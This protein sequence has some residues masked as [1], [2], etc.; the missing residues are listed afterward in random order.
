MHGNNNVGA[1]VGYHLSGGTMS[2]CSNAA[3]VAGEGRSVGG[4]AGIISGTITELL[5]RG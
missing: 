3:E 4:V 2:N 1:L 5:K